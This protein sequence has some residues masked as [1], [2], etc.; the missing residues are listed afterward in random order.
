MRLVELAEQNGDDRPARTR[1]S[2]ELERPGD[3]SLRVAGDV[4]EELLLE[5]E[6]LLR[7]RVQSQAGLRGLDAAT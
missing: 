4:F 2:S 1:R 5:R 6:E 3:R 7:R